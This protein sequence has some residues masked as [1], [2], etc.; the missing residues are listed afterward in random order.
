MFNKS[1]LI[2][3]IFSVN[4]F[5]GQT[6]AILTPDSK[7]IRIKGDI[8]EV[9]EGTKL[10]PH[11]GKSVKN[12]IVTGNKSNLAKGTNDTLSVFKQLD[13]PRNVNFGFF[14]QDVMIQWYVAPADLYIH[15]VGFSVADTTGFTN[16]DNVKL[17]LVKTNL[18][19]DEVK[20]LL[21]NGEATCLGHYVS[22]SYMNQQAPFP[23]WGNGEWVPCT[24]GIPE[25]WTEDIWSDF[26]DGYPVT[27]V[28][29]SG[30]EVVYNWVVLN[31]A[32]GFEPELIERNEVFGIAIQHGGQN[33]AQPDE[34]RI[35][36]LANKVGAAHPGFKYYATG[37]DFDNGDWWSRQYTWDF[38][39]AVEFMDVPPPRIDVTR[40]STTLSTGP[41]EVT[42]TVTAAYEIASASLFFSTDEMATWNEVAMTSTGNDTF[43]GTIPGMPPGTHVYYKVRVTDTEGNSGEAGPYDYFIFLPKELNLILYN[44]YTQYDDFLMAYYFNGKPDYYEN[45]DLWCYD[46]AGGELFAYY[47]NIYEITSKGPV[48]IYNDD[49]SVW[50]TNNVNNNYALFGDEWLGLQSNWTNGPHGAGE[51]QYDILGITYEYNDVN[52]NVTGDQTNSYPIYAVENSL[53]GGNIAD[54]VLFYGDTLLYDSYG[55]FGVPN[56]LDAVDFETDVSVDFTTIPVGTSENKPVA[57]HRTLSTGNKIVFMA[58]DPLFLTS[59]SV[60]F[61]VSA[62]SPL[63]KTCEWFGVPVSVGNN[64]NVP[65]KFKLMQNY[66]NPF[67]PV[68]TIKYSISAN[69]GVETLFAESSGHATSLRIY[70]V[71]G[72]EVAT[73]VNERQSPGTYT[74]QF[75]ASN[76]PSGVY[77]YTL[78]VGNFVATKKMVLLK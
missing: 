8:G 43:S 5:F 52:Y 69:V 44:G 66:P 68:T 4:I 12:I 77:F 78:R 30:D 9:I 76:L 41:R 38:V 28:R 59:D 71:L 1:L 23:W 31:D 61:G 17:L 33:P 27:N 37:R 62:A 70:N 49:I 11:N 32:L 6:K 3:F 36:F 45:F 67:N 21:I 74:V 56:W 24:E 14:S 65:T 73:L 72:E 2:A 63:I 48:A 7:L 18:S 47:K 35:G 42:A 54:S 51:F 50:L 40:L 19:E 22:D 46:V 25:I 75:D 39:A 16:G 34:E 58:F 53:L 10:I 26:G 57:G 60:W 55:I 29:A 13:L 20:G 15:A 64:E